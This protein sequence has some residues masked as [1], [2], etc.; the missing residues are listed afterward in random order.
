MVTTWHHIYFGLMTGARC[1]DFW[2]VLLVWLNRR[3]SV[4]ARSSL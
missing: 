2:L 4:Y 1:Y 3:I